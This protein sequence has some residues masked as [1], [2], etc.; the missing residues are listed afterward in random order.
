MG[1]R[2]EREDES[3]DDDDLHDSMLL[4]CFALQQT[5]LSIILLEQTLLEI[6]NPYDQ[7]P[8]HASKMLM[9]SKE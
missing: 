4:C 7:S 1:H 8:L 3:H 6:H 5:A 9:T 2:I